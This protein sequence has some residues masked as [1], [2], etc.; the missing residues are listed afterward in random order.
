M[1]EFA[2]PPMPEKIEG[3]PDTE[4]VLQKA[5]QD[6]PFEIAP[7]K[8]KIVEG[9]EITPWENRIILRRSQFVQA[10]RIVI[11]DKY[12]QQ[13]TTGTVV[14]LGPDV[15]EDLVKLGDVVVYGQYA[16]TP[17]KLRKGGPD[18]QDIVEYLVMRPDEIQGHLNVEEENVVQES[19]A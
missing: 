10:G 17:I 9:L 11:P 12:Q 8:A 19:K 5:F 2:F 4:P 15:P 6:P 13:G 3:E 1:T 14:G 18:S 7:R 16:G